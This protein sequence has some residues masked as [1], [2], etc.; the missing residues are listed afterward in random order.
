VHIDTEETEN[1]TP[2]C[3]AIVPDGNRRWAKK[4]GLSSDRGHREGYKKFKEVLNWAREI[5]IRTFV[6]FAL[7]TENLSKR[8]VQERLCLMTLFRD[9]MTELL[10]RAKEEHIRVEFVGD[11]S[12][13]NERLQALFRR[14]E[15]E[16]AGNDAFHLV[17][18]VG[19]GGRSDIVSS[20]SILA[21]RPP[22]D[23]L[24]EDDIREH[25]WTCNVSDIDLLIRSGGHRRLSN[26]ALWQLAYTELYF[27]DT[28]WPDFSRKEFDEA[29]YWYAAQQRNFGR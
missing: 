29:L 26:F 2:S 25:L 6:I 17:V 28:L 10:W 12:C 3:V 21:R 1:R 23:L 24:T 18:A 13:F 27:T 15:I 22:S 14:I 8:S 19:Y 5:G 9:A 4:A 11:H 7:S 16:T 20:T